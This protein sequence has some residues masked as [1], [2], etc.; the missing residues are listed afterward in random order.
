MKAL[1]VASDDGLDERLDKLPL[2]LTDQ[3]GN[4]NG[5]CLGFVIDSHRKVPNQFA[6]EAGG[7][8]RNR[9][10]IDCPLRT[11][12]GDQMNSKS[13]VAVK[14]RRALLKKV[15]RFA[16][17]TA[18]TVTLLLAAETKPASAVT[19]GEQCLVQC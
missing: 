14:S 18:P 1:L 19:S 3:P 10:D 9:N 4:K 17:V 13:E 8:C 15:A 11:N 7:A 12:R 2:R 5:S 16:A 6:E